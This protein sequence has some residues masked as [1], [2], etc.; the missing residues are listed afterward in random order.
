MARPKLRWLY[1]YLPLAIVLLLAGTLAWAY[2]QFDGIGRVDLG[3]ALTPA[4]GKSVNYLLVG[5]DSRAGITN[6]T[7]NSGAIGPQVAGSRSDTIIVLRVNGSS[8]SMMSVPRDLWA[9]NSQT[10]NVGKINGAYNQ[11]PANLVRTVTANLGIPINHYMEVDFVSFAGIVDAMGGIDINFPNPAFDTHSG[12]KQP[13]AGL[14]KLNGTQA[15]AYV[16]SRHYVEVINGR[17]VPDPTADL[18]REQRQ[19]NFIRTVLHDVGVTRNPW[20]LAQIAAAGAKGM[21][22]DTVLGFGDAFSLVRDLADSEPKTVVLPTRSARK[23]REDVLL[24]QT[25]AATPVLAGFGGS[26]HAPG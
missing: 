11:G 3:S 13:N 26:P 2:H 21:K 20:T 23:G 22:V 10:G 24:L 4:T 14:Q 7:P 6:S 18:G 15:L 16:R 25:A 8:A 17:F 5:S 19:Q 9:T 1:L 12:L